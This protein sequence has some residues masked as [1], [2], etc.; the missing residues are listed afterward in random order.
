MQTELALS[1]VSQWEELEMCFRYIPAQSGVGCLFVTLCF[2][3]CYPVNEMCCFF[4]RAPFFFFFL[5]YFYQGD[6]PV[7][8]LLLH[9]W[10]AAR[11]D[12]ASKCLMNKACVMERQTL[13]VLELLCLL[14]FRGLSISRHRRTRGCWKMI[15]SK[16]EVTHTRAIDRS[17]THFKACG[18]HSNG[19]V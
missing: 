3:F 5:L 19:N 13:C 17:C 7:T 4:C 11:E 8:S 18:E 2:C 6:L 14:S 12:C 16:K 15:T 10:H 1:Q 9:L